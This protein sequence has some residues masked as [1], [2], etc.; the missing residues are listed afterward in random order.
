MCTAF[1]YQGQNYILNHRKLDILEQKY[2]SEDLTQY[3]A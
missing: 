1:L 2:L 3:I